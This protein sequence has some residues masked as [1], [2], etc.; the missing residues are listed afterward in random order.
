MSEDA[1]KNVADA[2]VTEEIEAGPEVTVERT[3]PCTCEIKIVADAEFLQE[4]YEDELAKTQSEIAL[5]GFR[6]GRAPKGLVEKRM[7][8]ALCTDLISSVVRKA[9]SDAIEDEDIYVVGGADGPDPDDI[10]WR[11]GQPYEFTVQ[12]EMMPDVEMT[13]DDYFGLEVEAPQYAVTD[14]MLDAEKT[15]FMQ[16]FATR[17][18]VDSDAQAD[19]VV[20]VAASLAEPE[21]ASELV[22]VPNY[23][24]LGPFSYEDGAADA[25]VGAAVGDKLT[26][27]ATV[28]E[29]SEKWL[30]GS[31]VLA[32]IEGQ[33]VELQLEIAGIT[34]RTIPEL[35]AAFAERLGF[36]SVAEVEGTLTERIQASAEKATEDARR[37][38][39]LGA[40]LAKVE[41][42]MPDGLVGKATQDEQMRRLMRMLRSGMP[43]AQ[44]EQAA[45]EQAHGTREVVRR[46]LQSTFLLRKIAEAEKVLI[47]ESDVDEQIRVF[48]SEQNWQP[49]RA[50]R[51]LE[52]RD[53]VRSMRDDMREEATLD[54]LIKK[55]EITEVTP[56]EYGAKFARS[57]QTE[58]AETESAAQ[59]SDE[60]DAPE[61]ESDE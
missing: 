26:L 6:R 39:I 12:C 3:G 35:D 2:D 28:G 54:L 21:F 32:A 52:E 16:R 44:A 31:D 51:Y 37:D 57:A 59:E 38:V 40:L 25:V 23:G 29:D 7:S 33:A 49:D 53:L 27:A 22:L 41:C 48:A 46:R 14:E 42:E 30:E 5:P 17:E 20:R 9:C 15:Q 8:G 1:E 55:A 13:Q 45:L 18:E 61:Q 4:R 56:E 47:T 43:R 60:Q 11:P 50:R 36:E 19:D 34:R 10:D 24:K 58:S